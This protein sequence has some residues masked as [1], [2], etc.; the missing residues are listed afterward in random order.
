MTIQ[1]TATTKAAAANL[2]VI[3]YTDDTGSGNQKADMQ[4]ALTALGSSANGPYQLVWG[5]ATNDGV[6]SYVAQGADGSYAVTFRGSLTDGDAEGFF[7]NWVEDLD[8]LSLVPWVYPQTSGA[9]LSAG[10]NEALALAIAATDPTTDTTLID[11]LRTLQGTS[12]AI[13]VVGHSLGGAL[14]NLAATW[15][16]DQLPKSGGPK[17]ANIVPFT[18]AAPTV[19]DETFSKLFSSTFPVAYHAV[20]TLDIVPMAWTS[21]GGVT[22]SFSPPGQLLRSY[23]AALWALV[24]AARTVS[25]KYT[26]LS[27]ALDTFQGPTPTSA[28]SFPDEAT[29]EHSMSGTY[30]AHADPSSQRAAR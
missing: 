2:A 25:G 9:N 28:I 16:V 1:I 5:P 23:N 21:L 14:A 4:A 10:M 29:L 22:E 8:G 19:T 15:L 17:D 13:M 30:L 7:A 6:L 12:V 26:V 11:F 3:A 24:E 27:G 18:F 20:N